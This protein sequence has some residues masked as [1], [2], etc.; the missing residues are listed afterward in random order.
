[1]PAKTLF[2][3]M[4]LGATEAE[5][6]ASLVAKFGTPPFSV[7]DTKQGYWKERKKAWVALG[8]EG[9]VGRGQDSKEDGKALL[10]EKSQDRLNEIMGGGGFKTGISVFDPVVC[11]LMYR[12]FS[13]PGGF[14]C[15][16]FAGGSVRGV[17]AGRVGRKY[18]GIDLRPEQVEA[19]KVQ[20]EKI[21][22]DANV[23]WLVG[24]AC[25]MP[26]RDNPPFDFVFTCPPYYDLEIYSDDK[27][28]L[29]NF[30][31]YKQFITAYN[32]VIA[33]AAKLLKP[34]RFACYVVGDIRDKQGLYRNFVSDTIAGFAA[35]GMALYNE[36]I[37]V[38]AVGSLPI[39]ITRQ[40]NAGRKIG[41]MHQ[42][43]L[44]FI[45][46]DPKVATE[47]CGEV[48]NYVPF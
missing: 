11:E 32:I 48:E 13:P 22:P 8:I 36:I 2:E 23:N 33:K 27:K 28:D 42:N 4:E 21:C 38:T 14:V 39:R 35:A 18:M 29:S 1:M 6:H 3:E 43:I 47:V 19:N 30:K 31:T 16:P 46:G 45:K 17:V 37:L 10:M 12:W 5:E 15:D 40:F 41:K 26:A 34:N 20:K 24:D 9:E 44:V 25:D 7:L